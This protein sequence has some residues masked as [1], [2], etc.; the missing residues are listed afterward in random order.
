MKDS[1]KKTLLSPFLNTLTPII[2]LQDIRKA[3][4]R[5]TTSQERKRKNIEKEERREK[6]VDLNGESLLCC[7]VILKLSNICFCF[8]FSLFFFCSVERNVFHFIFV[9]FSSP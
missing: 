5:T 7:Y 6:E 2:F 1:F 8:V 3:H 4:Q 9:T